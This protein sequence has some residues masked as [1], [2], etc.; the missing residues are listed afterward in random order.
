MAAADDPGTNFPTLIASDSNHRQQTPPRSTGNHPLRLRGPAADARAGRALAFAFPTRD[1]GL[2]HATAR[3]GRRPFSGSKPTGI[4]SR[5]P[6]RSFTASNSPCC[7]VAQQ[8]APGWIIEGQA[9]W[10]GEDVGGPSPV[11]HG[12]WAAYLVAPT[13]SLF[14]REYNAVG[15]Y[16]HLAETGTSPWSV[17]DA[18]LSTPGNSAAAFTA[19]GAVQVQLPRHLGVRRLAHEALPASLVCAGSLDDASRKRR[20]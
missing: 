19:S 5:W 8:A 11:R 16:E 18:M 7:R 12:W 17:F 10:A 13:L 4:A 15:F 2:D 6:T 20:R 3:F 1:S 9:E 14:A